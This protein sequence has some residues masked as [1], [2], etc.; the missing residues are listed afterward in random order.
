M[1]LNGEVH[2]QHRRLMMPAFH[3][4][5][6]ERY[7]RTMVA[8]TEETL[9]HWKAGEGRNIQQEMMS[10]TRRIATQTLFGQDL[11]DGGTESGAS[12]K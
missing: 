11:P 8:L 9:N 4:K 5:R 7:Y 1:G 10:L 6:I 2:R 3:K 12:C